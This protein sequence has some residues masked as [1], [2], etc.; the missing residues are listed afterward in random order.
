MRPSC[1]GGSKI[2]SG[3]PTRSPSPRTG[4]RGPPTQRRSVRIPRFLAEELAAQVLGKGPEDL[5]STSP[6]GGVLRNTNFRPRI[7]DPACERSG[8]VGLTPHELRHTA[9]SLAVAAGA[10]VK[11]VQQMLGHASAAMTL[12]VYAGLFGDDLDALADRLDEAFAGAGCGPGADWSPPRGP[13]RHRDASVRAA[14]QGCRW[15][16]LR[17]S[18]SRPTHYECVALPSELRRPARGRRAAHA[19]SPTISTAPGHVE[20][21]A[22]QDHGG[23]EPIRAASWYSGSRC[24]GPPG[25]RGRARRGAGRIRSGRRPCAPRPPG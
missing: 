18:N 4:V 16:R 19:R 9:A 6:G 10:N 11:V 7:F 24:P 3:W 5:V 25:P 1:F 17:E 23:L 22:H 12:D 15:G 21:A 13:C 2:G 8:L 14:D 20:A